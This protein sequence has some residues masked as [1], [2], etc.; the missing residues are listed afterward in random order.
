MSLYGALGASTFP[1]IGLGDVKPIL[2]DVQV[3]GAHLHGAKLVQAVESLVK[4][5]ILVGPFDPGQQLGQP[6]QGQAVQFAALTGSSQW[7]SGSKSKRFPSRKRPV[8]RMRR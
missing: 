2:Q 1:G 5:I 4:F 3:D 6:G 8:L 7:V